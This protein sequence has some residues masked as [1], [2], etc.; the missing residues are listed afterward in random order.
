[1]LAIKNTT[2][3]RLESMSIIVD[4][5]NN[6]ICSIKLENTSS[7][8]SV[9]SFTRNLHKNDDST[10][11]EE[12]DHHQKHLVIVENPCMFHRYCEWKL[13]KV[14]YGGSRLGAENNR[15]K[16]GF[17]T[18][19][20]C[21]ETFIIN[22]VQLPSCCYFRCA[23]WRV[24]MHWESHG[25][26]PRSEILSVTLQP[27]YSRDL[28]VTLYIFSYMRGMLFHTD[29]SLSLPGCSSFLI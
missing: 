10:C 14:L 27:L 18:W 5:A 23:I 13:E 3:V 19:S 20:S 12:Q 21:G 8:G 29:L 7:A 25:T 1:M 2:A 16:D 17:L 26:H 22:H 24:L 11:I 28:R 9:W 4:V 6:K 15:F